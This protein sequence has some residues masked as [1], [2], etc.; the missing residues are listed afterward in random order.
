MQRKATV[1]D[2]DA[3]DFD[4]DIADDVADDE[5]PGVMAAAAEASA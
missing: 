5:L 1:N 3:D 4:G 2:G